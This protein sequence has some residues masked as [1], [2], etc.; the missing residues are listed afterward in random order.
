MKT[1]MQYMKENGLI[2]NHHGSKIKTKWE[3]RKARLEKEYKIS[4]KD[5]TFD[6]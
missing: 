4:R 2:G 6:E 3:K 1:I 5:T